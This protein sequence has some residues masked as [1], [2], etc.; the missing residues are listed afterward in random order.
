MPHM[1]NN[2]HLQYRPRNQ[3]GVPGPAPECTCS[4]VPQMALHHSPRQSLMH[5]SLVLTAPT[6]PEPSAPTRR[7]KYEA[8]GQGGRGAGRGAEWIQKLVGFIQPT[9]FFF[10]LGALTNALSQ[11]PFP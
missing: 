10:N 3:C 1:A 4:M 6:I 11:I 7:R 5:S 2:F 8:G 9:I